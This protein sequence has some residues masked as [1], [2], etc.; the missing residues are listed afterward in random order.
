[1]LP[2]P[3]TLAF[4]SAIAIAVVAM[5]GA[6]RSSQQTTD[7][8]QETQIWRA[9]AQSQYLRANTL[10]VAVVNGKATLTGKVEGQLSKNLAKLIALGVEGVVEVDNQIVAHTEAPLPKP[11]DRSDK[12]AYFAEHAWRGSWNGNLDESAISP[13]HK[14]V[15]P[16]PPGNRTN[17]G[18]LSGGA[19]NPEQRTPAFGRAQSRDEA[20]SVNREGFKF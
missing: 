1:M 8:R 3:R 20:N 9:Y 10:E 16:G 12:P 4:T 19:D 6:D 15:D 5:S 18:W 11:P 13:A 14:A 7:A 2:Y 17:S